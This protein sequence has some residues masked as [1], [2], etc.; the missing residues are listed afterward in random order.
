M[1]YLTLMIHFTHFVLFS[2][3]DHLVF[4]NVANESKW[5]KIMDKEIAAIEENHWCDMGLQDI[6]K[7]K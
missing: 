6:A 3:C 2:N 4:K 1:R 7:R 5:R